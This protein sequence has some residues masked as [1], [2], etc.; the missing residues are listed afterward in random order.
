MGVSQWKNIF[1]EIMMT[2]PILLIHMF[3]ILFIVSIK[4]KEWKQMNYN[5]NI[6][7]MSIGIRKTLDLYGCHNVI[8]FFHSLETLLLMR[9]QS[10]RRFHLL[11]NRSFHKEL[12]ELKWRVVHFIHSL[13]NILDGRAFISLALEYMF[14]RS[15]MKLND[16]TIQTL[17][18]SF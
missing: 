16:Y 4:W 10:G 5:G 8:Q 18:S 14:L 13:K 2:A 11:I 7:L 17:M 1:L 6:N 3:Y 9:P 12:K 15:E